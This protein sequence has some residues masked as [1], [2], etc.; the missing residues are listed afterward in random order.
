MD[1]PGF[2]V[3]VR[4]SVSVAVSMPVAVAAAGESIPFAAGRGIAI[5]KRLQLGRIFP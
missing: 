2:P 5:Q 3:A 1:S 4:V